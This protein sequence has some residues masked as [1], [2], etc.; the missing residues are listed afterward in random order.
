MRVCNESKK[1]NGSQLIIF[2]ANLNFT[3]YFCDCSVI[4]YTSIAFLYV[5]MADSTVTVQETVKKTTTTTIVKK[6]YSK[7][8]PLGLLKISKDDIRE[9]HRMFSEIIKSKDFTGNYGI[10]TTIRFSDGLFA[11]MTDEHFEEALKDESEI[12]GIKIKLVVRQPPIPPNYL[13]PNYVQVNLVTAFPYTFEDDYDDESDSTLAL[14]ILSENDAK[15]S[16]VHPLISSVEENKARISHLEHLKDDITKYLENK[17]RFT[18]SFIDYSGWGLLPVFIVSTIAM[19]SV[20]IFQNKLSTAENFSVAGVSYAMG[21]FAWW[22]WRNAWLKH[23]HVIFKS[24]KPGLLS[25]IKGFI[26]RNQS[27]IEAGLITICVTLV[28][29]FLGWLF[30]IISIQL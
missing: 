16:L 6:P 22:I 10:L 26:T 28:L 5:F 18:N 1:R 14:L 19:S 17:R 3:L 13:P 30:G 25:K 7:E 24:E 2:S 11:P 27:N 15:F 20:V 9:L 4:L 29:G 12:I 21:F 8:K 23:N